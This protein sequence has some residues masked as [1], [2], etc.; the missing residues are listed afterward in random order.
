[1][2]QP[3][4]AKQ[5]EGAIERNVPLRETVGLR[6]VLVWTTA[7]RPAAARETAAKA[8]RLCIES[9][10]SG[11]VSVSSFFFLSFSKH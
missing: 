4:A 8:W 3:T 1:M 2:S 7:V 9:E 6:K 5:P 10:Q 11:L